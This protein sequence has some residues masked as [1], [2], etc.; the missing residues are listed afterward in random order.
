MS[1]VD[2]TNIK[3]DAVDKAYNSVKY[4]YIKAVNRTYKY[5]SASNHFHFKEPIT[6]ISVGVAFLKRANGYKP[7]LYN[8]TV[9]GCKFLRIGGNPL[10]RFMHGIFHK[11]SNINHTCPY[12]H[13]IEVN[14]LP[15]SH[16]DNI[17]SK[18]LPF[19]KGDYQVVTSWYTYNTLRTVVKLYYTLS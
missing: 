4:C 2:F 7:F 19:P 11:Y 13:D 17:F 14:E 9:D 18:V 1:K 6:N 3:C 5:F 8:V 16:A 12:T 10:L 15:V